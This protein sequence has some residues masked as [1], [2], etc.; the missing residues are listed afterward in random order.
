MICCGLIVAASCFAAGCYCHS[1]ST[2]A[3]AIGNRALPVGI[4]SPRVGTTDVAPAG[5]SSTYQRYQL[6]RRKLARQ[7]SEQEAALKAIAPEPPESGT[8]TQSPAAPAN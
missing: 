3:T 2:T 1:G 4:S 8:V 7:K 5:F 6:D